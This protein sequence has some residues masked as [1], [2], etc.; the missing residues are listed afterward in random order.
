VRW[1]K[2][3]DERV[4]SKIWVMP[5]WSGVIYKVVSLFL[6]FLFF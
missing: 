1:L 2:R 3:I 6:L 4:P 5:N